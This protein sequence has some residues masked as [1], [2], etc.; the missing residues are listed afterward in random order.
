MKKL[1]LGLLVLCA[2]TVT[3]TT[4]WHNLPKILFKQIA[5]FGV[6]HQGLRF[7]HT[8]DYTKGSFLSKDYDK[9]CICHQREQSDSRVSVK[10][11][12]HGIHIQ[13]NSSNSDVMIQIL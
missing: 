9:K 3:W 13:K 6:L 11:T 10:N 4:L 12:M 2:D 8:R 7:F 1:F 5:L